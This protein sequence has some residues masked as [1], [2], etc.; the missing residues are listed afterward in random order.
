MTLMLGLMT[1]ITNIVRGVSVDKISSSCVVITS[2]VSS[3]WRGKWLC[4]I[5]QHLHLTKV[6][7]IV[8][9]SSSL[10]NN[11][12]ILMAVVRRCSDVRDGQWVFDL[13]TDLIESVSWGSVSG[14]GYI[15]SPGYLRYYLG[16]RECVWTIMADQSPRIELEVVDLAPRDTGDRCE[17]SLV[18]LSCHSVV[19][20]MAG[21]MSC[22]T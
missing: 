8:P 16:G 2:S 3:V 13:T 5:R 9:N 6:R 14:E 17:D 7:Q 18:S 11:R 20:W 21:P 10:H 12:D 22:P 4:F 15:S 1:G 19:I